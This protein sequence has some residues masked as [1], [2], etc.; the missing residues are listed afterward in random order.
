MKK[1]VDFKSQMVYIIINDN[2]TMQHSWRYQMNS[3]QAMK[4]TYINLGLVEVTTDAQLKR[5]NI[6]FEDKQFKDAH[7]FTVK[8]TFHS[9]GY[10]RRTTCCTKI[11]YWNQYNTW[12]QTSNYQLNPRDAYDSRIMIYDRIEQMVRCI[13][14]VMSYRKLYA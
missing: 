2:T 11:S 12:K 14:N 6:M 1:V 9:N 3:I 13:K 10:Y 8:Y 5:G 7:G 4:Q